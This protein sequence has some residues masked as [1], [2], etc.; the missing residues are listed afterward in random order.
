MLVFAR[1]QIKIII[2]VLVESGVSLAYTYFKLQHDQLY[3]V[4]KKGVDTV[5]QQLVPQPFC[6]PVLDLAHGHMLGGHLGVEKNTD[7]IVGR[8]YWPGILSIFW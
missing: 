3:R 1:E 5:E 8:F 6:R 7:R 4:D 2:E